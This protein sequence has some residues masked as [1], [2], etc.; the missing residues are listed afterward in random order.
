MTSLYR[1]NWYHEDKNMTLE[2]IAEKKADRKKVKKIYI[3]SFPSYERMPFFFMLRSIKKQDTELLGIY[4]DDVL[5]GFFYVILKNDIC[6]LLYFAIDEDKRSSGYGSR[7]IGLISKKYEDKRIFLY[8][9]ETDSNSNNYIQTKRRKDFY[10]RNGFTVTDYYVVL[11]KNRFEI[12][13]YGKDICR[14]EY[15]SILKQMTGG[16]NIAKVTKKS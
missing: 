3:S 13:N 11:S 8:I 6:L 16:K 5:V 14:E 2:N 7:A 15:V 12:L 4:D 10:V 9:E 1:N